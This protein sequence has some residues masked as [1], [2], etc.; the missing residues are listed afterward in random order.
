MKNIKKYN[1][2]SKKTIIIILGAI[3]LT[4]TVGYVYKG[5]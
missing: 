3:L 4:S 2:L 1:I 5:Y